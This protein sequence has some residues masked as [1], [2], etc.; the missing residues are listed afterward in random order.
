MSRKRLRWFGLVIAAAVTWAG[1]LLTACTAPPLQLAPLLEP[2][3]QPKAVVRGL[4]RQPYSA[5]KPR[6]VVETK[7][8]APRTD[9]R[10]QLALLPKDAS[11]R[12]DWVR[13][14]NDGLIS[15]SP[16]LDPKAEAQPVLDLNVELVPQVAPEFKAT[17][18]HKA[19][20]QLLGCANCHPAIFKMDRSGDPITM[21]RIFAGEYCGRCHGKVAFDVRTGCPRCHLGMA[22]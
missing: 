13:A 9:W 20:T 19:H 11:G 3:P 22:Q 21:E 7:E 2:L 12:T 10:A 5:L 6:S 14:L 4:R 16:G 18:S 15:P 1:Y 17:F 8:E